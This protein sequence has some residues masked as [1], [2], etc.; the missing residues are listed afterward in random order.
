M[1]VDGAHNGDS[2]EKLARALPDY[3]RF[4]AA[5]LVVGTSRDKDIAGIVEGLR[6]LSAKVIVTRSRNPRAAEYL[7]S[8]R[9]SSRPG[10]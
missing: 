2:A 8:Q 6:P 4:N 3:F 9:L 1:V 5:I 10:E 7:R